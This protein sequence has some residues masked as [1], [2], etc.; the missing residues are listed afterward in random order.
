MRKFAQEGYFYLASP[1]AGS[2]E[3]KERRVTQVSQAAASLLEQEVY[4]WSPVV[5]N[6]QLVPYIKADLSPEDRRNLFMPYDLQLL[7]QSRG[8]ILLALEGWENSKGVLEEIEFCK[9]HRIDIYKTTLESLTPFSFEKWL[10]S[11]A[12]LKEA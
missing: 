4:A 1:Y 9:F 8:M 11:S 7:K 6:H 12:K 3:E 5:H 2:S 10:P